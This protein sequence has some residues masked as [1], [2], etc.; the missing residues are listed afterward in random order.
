MVLRNGFIPYRR[1]DVEFALETEMA[2]TE[3][4]IRPRQDLDPAARRDDSIM[5][6]TKI[7]AQTRTRSHGQEQNQQLW[8]PG[9]PLAIDVEDG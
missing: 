2:N 9:D 6:R 4:A 5:E 3:R 7:R 8:F 1:E